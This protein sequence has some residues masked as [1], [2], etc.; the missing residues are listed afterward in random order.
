M[1]RK[2]VKYLKFNFLSKE[3]Y[4]EVYKAGKV[5]PFQLYA[6]EDDIEYAKQEDVD[7]L[8]KEKADKDYVVSVF[9]QLKQLILNGNIESAVA[10]LDEAILDLSTL[11]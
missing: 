5:E 8:S 1:I 10:V 4:E 7:K 9:E 3:Q 11:G 2:I 6:V